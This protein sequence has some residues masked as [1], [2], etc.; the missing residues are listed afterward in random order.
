[1]PLAFENVN[2][3]SPM[4]VCPHYIVKMLQ[5]EHAQMLDVQA[6]GYLVCIR[7]RADDGQRRYFCV[8]VTTLFQKESRDSS[9]HSE[10]REF[11]ICNYTA[12]KTQ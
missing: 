5:Y 11:T 2:K 8:L 1:M 6:A 4:L 12:N 7:C 9:M 10:V 3:A